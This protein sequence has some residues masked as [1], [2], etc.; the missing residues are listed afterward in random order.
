MLTKAKL[1]SI[2]EL[3]STSE[4]INTALATDS[5]MAVSTDVL[6]RSL[7]TEVVESHAKPSLNQV[8]APIRANPH[9]HIRSKILRD[10]FTFASEL[11]GT[12]ASGNTQYSQS[13][14][15][16]ESSLL[17]FVDQAISK[18]KLLK[19]AADSSLPHNG[20]EKVQFITGEKGV[21]KTH[22]QNFIISRYWKRFDKS[23]V[24]WIRV[25]LIRDFFR[26]SSDSDLLDWIKAQIT[27]VATRYYDNNSEYLRKS[28]YSSKSDQQ[29]I[30]EKEDIEMSRQDDWNL[31]VEE[32][33][34]KYI[35]SV[36]E[37][38]SQTHR[39]LSERMR[40]MLSR[41]QTLK[42]DQDTSQ[43][44]IPKEFADEIFI[45]AQEK[46][47][48][49][50]VVF[51]GLDLLSVS[52]TSEQKYLSR[53]NLICNYLREEAI[54]PILN[55]VFLRPESL[56][57]FMEVFE[58]SGAPYQ[59]ALNATK[60][61]APC[62]VRQMIFK[63]LAFL[64]DPNSHLEIDINDVTR[65]ESYIC[66]ERQ[67]VLEAASILEYIELVSGGN[68]RSATQTLSMLCMGF[69][70]E[71]DADYHFTELAMKCAYPYPPTDYIYS[72]DLY[73]KIERS[74][75][76]VQCIFDAIFLPSIVKFPCCENS[77][78]DEALPGRRLDNYILGIRL[79]QILKQFKYLNDSIPARVIEILDILEKGFGYNRQIVKLV[80]DELVDADVLTADN[81][82]V[83][84]SSN[85]IENLSICISSKGEHILKTCI[86]DPTY[87]ALAAIVCPFPESLCFGNKEIETMIRCKSPDTD[88]TYDWVTAK[89]INS[90]NLY[91]TLITA[92]ERQAE[93]ART[94]DLQELFNSY[95]D[96]SEWKKIVA[97]IVNSDS[98]LYKYLPTLKNQLIESLYRAIRG[99]K[100][101][102]ETIITDIEKAAEELDELFSIEE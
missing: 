27:K 29:E 56:R 32:I 102:A 49:F 43:S 11:H 92:N 41:L 34:S 95:S 44:W 58:A 26:G 40:V 93:T 53:R 8:F 61:V 80:I 69:N 60:N 64:T 99:T 3:F 7:L 55:L 2:Y 14:N 4:Y 96:N 59:I 22:L 25:N 30:R 38:D 66:Q 28:A 24:M 54:Q 94:T 91:K 13:I 21:G 50:I 86:C 9:D 20:L 89:A 18:S 78:I 68:I 12:T 72:R 73:G 81:S 84:I 45:A 79:L 83:G 23:K 1:N 35:D 47:Y 51:D 77:S 70:G 65:F 19:K 39:E 98:N 6:P 63:K 10:T 57:D 36:A 71:V 5:E 88:T 101:G 52:R 76:P 37:D 42:N 90:I 67:D 17:E 33:L 16:D 97:E 74:N 100:S 87:L 46:G 15:Y 85:R 48:S 82:L 62:D 75:S 31:N